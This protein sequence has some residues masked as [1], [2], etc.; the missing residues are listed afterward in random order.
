L[1]AHGK[2]RAARLRPAILVIVSL[3]GLA[4]PASASAPVI[5]AGS[6]WLGGQ[7][8]NICGPST[9][10]YCGG[11]QHVGGISANWW[12]CVE[13]AQRLYQAR[14]W[15]GGVFSGVGGAYQI[16]DNASALGMSRQPNGSISALVPGDMIIHGTDTGGGFG[17]VSIVDSVAGSTVNVVEQNASPN[18]RAT[19]SFN[20]ST[21]SRSATGTIRGVVH[22]PGN[23][24]GGGASATNGSY[25]VASDT[26]R[27]YVMAGGSPMY[28]SGWGAVGG[29]K[30]ISATYTQAQINSMPQYPADGTA[31]RNYGNGAIYVVAG[32]FGFGVS[33]LAHIPNTSWVD[34]D[35]SALGQL[36]SQPG[37]GTVVRDYVSG[38]IYVVSGNAAMTV[39]SLSSIPYTSWTNVDGWAIAN[40]LNRYPTDGSAIVD[41]NTGTVYIIAGG[42]AMAV[43]SFNNI[44]PVTSLAYV[45]HWVL[46]N[47]LRQ[48]PANGTVVRDYVSGGIYVIA[49]GSALGIASL[50]NVP[51]VNW[52]NV[53]GWSISNQLLSYP[54]DGTYVR[55]Y[56]TGK[57]YVVENGGTTYLPSWGSTGPQP[58][59]EVDQWA[60]T[61]QLG[62]T[63]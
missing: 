51:Y 46:Q 59:T 62:A 1:V 6:A 25:V 42:S 8:V 34:I 23:Q 2:Q 15:H 32:G 7:G 24:S 55:G 57:I 26:S 27:V 13:L 60:I 47:Q 33:S 4:T 43:T 10:P 61:N 28:V 40:Q 56:T 39:T 52:V 16:Y 29:P 48:H 54:T 38:T 36:R 44:P 63:G 19:Y 22:D 49:G 5:I 58:Y 35:G 45:D 50:S 53:D 9:D 3:I 11:Q 20:G 12:Q 30:P 37:D 21:L 18:G 17:H 31:V 14:G 41:Y